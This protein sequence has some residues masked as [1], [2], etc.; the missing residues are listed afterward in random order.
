VLFNDTLKYNIAYGGVKDSEFKAKL[1][2]E[3]NVIVEQEVM[4]EI[5]KVS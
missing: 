1:E 2:N 4:K 3:N 5:V